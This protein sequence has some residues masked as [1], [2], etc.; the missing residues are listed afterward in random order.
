MLSLSSIQ[1]VSPPPMVRPSL[2]VDAVRSSGT[3][4]PLQSIEPT[5]AISKERARVEN[6]L[7]EPGVS[8]QLAAATRAPSG[9]SP[10]DL[11]RVQRPRSEQKPTPDE[12]PLAEKT[13]IQ[14]A[15]DTQIKGLLSNVWKASG[16][17]VDFLL[18]REAVEQ[19]E[20]ASKAALDFQSDIWPI[21]KGGKDAQARVVLNQPKDG[22]ASAVLSYTAQGSAEGEKVDPRGQ[23]LDY[24]A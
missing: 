20:Q 10:A 9:A 18:G 23:L 6:K 22:S 3:S 16:K 12:Q 17:A 4:N 11:G 2:V 7:P 13:P 15:L 19:A 1:S 14:K 5:T 21:L 24:V 8:V